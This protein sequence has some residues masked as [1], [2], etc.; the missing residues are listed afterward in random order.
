MRI[1]LPLW[2][3]D[4]QIVLLSNLRG[5][6]KRHKTFFFDEQHV[7]KSVARTSRGKL[8]V[9]LRE[10]DLCPGGSRAMDSGN[11]LANTQRSQIDRA[12]SVGLKEVSSPIINHVPLRRGFWILVR[13]V[14]QQPLGEVLVVELI[15]AG[16]RQNR[17]SSG[18][19]DLARVSRERAA[20]TCLEVRFGH[21]GIG[22]LFD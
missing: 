10:G 19:H 20:G 21:D 12:P 3:D 1:A 14:R 13:E 22:S 9:D 7:P 5:R 15:L 6:Q 4:C 16:H 17:G 2:R 11:V 18:I 8:Q